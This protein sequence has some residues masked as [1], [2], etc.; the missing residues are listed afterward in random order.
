[1]PRPAA[2]EEPIDWRDE[3]TEE[4]EPI[5]AEAVTTAAP[6]KV[7]KK[8]PKA[9]PK[10]LSYARA[11]SVGFDVRCWRQRSGLVKKIRLASN[12]LLLSLVLIFCRCLR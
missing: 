8:R 4:A 9:Q 1:M 5:E 7:K 3:E 12:L 11:T 6:P 10:Q 2:E